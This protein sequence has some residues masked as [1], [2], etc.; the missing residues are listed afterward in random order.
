MTNIEK[1]IIVVTVIGLSVL[2]P[3]AI[4]YSEALSEK[5]KKEEMT[6]EVPL[7]IENCQTTIEAYKN[8][9]SCDL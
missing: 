8:N 4:K 9:C 1:I 5:N 2:F 6:A 7:T 3:Y